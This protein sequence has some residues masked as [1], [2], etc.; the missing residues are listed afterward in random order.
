MKLWVFDL[1]GT[2]ITSGIDYARVV[3]LWGLMFLEEME[4]R[5]P[6]YDDFLPKFLEALRAVDKERF[7]TMRA[8]RE[9]WPGSMVLAYKEVCRQ[10]E[11]ELNPVIERKTWEIGVSALSEETYRNRGM[12]PGVEETLGLLQSRGE[13]IYCITAGDVRVQWMKWRGYNL[14]RFFPSNREFRVVKW[15]KLP[16]LERLR[17]LRPDLQA[18]MVGDS[19]GSDLV[20][21]AKLGYLPVFVPHPSVWD[22]GELVNH[23]PEGTIL[24]EKITELT[25]V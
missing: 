22:H 9:R 11:L 8:H 14:R 13:P 19:I 10:M 6:N 1:D 20:P 17:R 5:A 16:T 25:S 24:L 15:E 23:P 12:M 4:H 7:K 18:V 3:F 21:A 2:L